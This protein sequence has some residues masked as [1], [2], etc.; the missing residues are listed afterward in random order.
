ML[1]PKFPS[2]EKSKIWH[3]FIFFIQWYLAPDDLI[4]K[5]CQ[6]WLHWT[7]FFM[8]QFMILKGF[9]LP[10]CLNTKILVNAHFSQQGFWRRI[11]TTLCPFVKTLPPLIMFQGNPPFSDSLPKIRQLFFILSI[12]PLK[13]LHVELCLEYW[14]NY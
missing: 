2:T 14:W 5:I 6:S 3:L 12:S 13:T 1:S 7:M 9:L 8:L 11:S 4:S 10:P